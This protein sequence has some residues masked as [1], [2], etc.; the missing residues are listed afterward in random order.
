MAGRT[1]ITVITGPLGSGKTT[2]LRHILTVMPRKIAILMNEFGEIAIDTKILQGKNVEMADLGGGCVCCSLLGEFEAAVDEIITTVDPDYLVVETTGV[3]EPDALVFD[4]QESLPQVRLDGVITVMDADG[5]VKYPQVGH[6][7]RIQIEAA[8]ILLLNKADLVSDSELATITDKLHTLNEVTSIIPTV[9]CQIDPDLLFGIGRERSQPA[10]HHHHQP[11]FE[12]FS[13][14]SQA[15]FDRPRFAE[16]A[17][18]LSP[19]VYRAKGFVQFPEGTHLFNF[20]AGRWDLEP[21][22]PAPT[23]LVFIGKQITQQQTQICDRLQSCELSKR[24]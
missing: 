6:T 2:L 11:E 7:S 8:D 22:E 10:P 18:S 17:D 20:V 3:A 13:Y 16:F 9:R 1:P 5:M 4:I 24:H 21:F 23:K 15:V 14:T 12:S 19:D